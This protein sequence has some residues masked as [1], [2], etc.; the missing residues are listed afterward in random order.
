[1]RILFNL[2]Y[3]TKLLISSEDAGVLAWVLSRAK[4]VNDNGWGDTR[5]LSVSEDM[6][7]LEFTPDKL[8]DEIVWGTPEVAPNP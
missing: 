5:K 4:L 7:T 8:S 3:G 1:M 2:S 6:P